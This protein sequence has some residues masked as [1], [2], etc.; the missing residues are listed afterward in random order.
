MKVN[1]VAAI[2]KRNF[3]G[4]FSSPIGYVFICALVLL[5]AFAAF[6]P[7]EFFNANLANLD[8]LNRH[9]PWIML[10]F[11]P[12][13][14]MSIWAQ[15]RQQGTDELLLTLPARDFDVVIGKYLAALAIF[16]LALVF[17][18]SNIVVLIGL[19]EPDLGL[20][21]A[22]YVGYWFV[23]AA[24]L[25][26]GMAASFLTNNLTIGFIL[27][28]AFNAPLAFAASADA[29][30]P[31]ADAARFVMGLSIA[32]QFRDFGRG[33]ITVSGAVF[34]C[35]IVVVMLYLSM[36]L[37]GRRHWVGQRASMPMAGHYVLRALAL[38]AVALGL[39]VLA[40]RFDRRVDVSLEKLSSLSAHTRELLGRIEPERPV[41]VEA[42]VSPEVP[43]EYVQTRLNLL[44]MLREV[45]SLGG[46]RVIVRINDT[47][48][49]SEQAAEAEQQFG[50]TARR[51]PATT[52]GKFSV[53]EIILGAAVMCGL[54]NVVVPFF[55]RGLP[56]EY[57]IVR[58]IATVSQQQRKRIGVLMTDARLYGGFDIQTMSA[59]PNQQIID[60]LQK[61]YEVVQVN[62][63]SPISERYD[64]LLAVQ[65]SSLPQPPLD[66]FLDAV[67]RGQPTAIFEDPF[68]FLDG[69]VAATSQPRRPPGG[70]NPFVQQRQMPE[71]KGDISA[72]WSLLQV[73]FRDRDVVWDAYNPYPKITQFP[74][75]FV[76]IGT[77]SGSQ[78]PFSSRSPITSGLQ[79]VLLVFPG[80]VRARMG[81][82]LA[83]TPLLE[84]GQQTGLVAF[85]EIL[86]RSFLG[87][88]GLNP[89]RRLQPTRERY[90]MAAHIRGEVAGAEPPADGDAQPDE[91][92]PETSRLDVVLVADIDVLYSVFFAMRARGN[93]PDAPQ[94]NVDNVTFVLNI[95]DNLAR[96]DR[97]IDIRKRRPVHRTLTA[98]EKRTERAREVADDEREDFI[99]QFEASRT[100]EEAKLQEKINELEGREGVDPQQM[101]LEIATAQ[102]VGQQRLE[103][104]VERLEQERDRQVAKIERDLALEVRRVEHT[105]KLM[106]VALPPIPPLA[107]AVVVF[108][109][110]R[111]LERIGVPKARL[112]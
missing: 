95:L 24:M 55:D 62:A 101:V 5:G 85:D 57:E 50:I 108:F 10:V 16:T 56:V 14:T 1:V 17:S 26:I 53:D 52:G 110:R 74:P 89:N 83:L 35:S 58:S 100:E 92:A 12:A 49:Y 25:S 105:Y 6:W 70:N 77:G 111:R 8:Q 34:F 37:I 32:E 68:P 90:T 91:R 81:S 93:E 40:N 71:P 4:Y 106:A 64:A 41:Y 82:T 47:E 75:E 48:R 23:G 27:G 22:N 46:D 66:N 38:A 72:L 13:V 44:S 21:A 54:D 2:L 18:L 45:D 97:F 60:E 20:L 19:G 43:Q 112:R 86:Q 98:V 76:F 107:V 33:L 11:I 87:P 36:V 88:A 7:H 102:R 99:R 61:Q 51:V 69:N 63:S 84:A 30:I 31:Q 79:Q 73:E 78:E 80:A 67:R 59:R 94:I 42:Y 96:D 3:V 15:E 9:L 104:A 103:T 29:I 39:V 109:R 65:P 28:A